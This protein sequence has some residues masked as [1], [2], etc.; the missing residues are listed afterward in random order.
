MT[1]KIQIKTTF[2]KSLKS[3]SMMLSIYSFIFPFNKNFGFNPTFL[4][5]SV[6]PSLPTRPDR[7][8]NSL[9]IFASYGKLVTLILIETRT[10]TCEHDLFVHLCYVIHEVHKGHYMNNCLTLRCSACI[11]DIYETEA[12]HHWCLVTVIVEVDQ[13]NTLVSSPWAFIWQL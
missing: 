13:I 5:S 7:V 9:F 11:G 6:P 10:I 1:F 3:F 8:L 12:Y 4:T 2:W